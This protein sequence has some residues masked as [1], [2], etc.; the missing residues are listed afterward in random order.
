MT[1]ANKQP[2]WE[3]ES[4]YSCG[5]SDLR[6]IAKH[7][8][9]AC[10]VCGACQFKPKTPAEIQAK[11]QREAREELAWAIDYWRRAS[12]RNWNPTELRGVT[13][14]VEQFLRDWEHHE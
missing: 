10:N 3:P 2:D 9:W 7:E 5:F 12:N 11:Q 6:W 13:E 14:A 4:C 1:Q 8:E